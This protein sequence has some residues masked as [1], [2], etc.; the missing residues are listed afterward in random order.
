[1]HFVGPAD[2][3]N[4]FFWSADFAFLC[5]PVSGKKFSTVAE[6]HPH[7]TIEMERCR[8]MCQESFRFQQGCQ[9]FLGATYQNG[10]KCTKLTQIIPNGHKI[11][12]M[13][14]K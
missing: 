10:E 4:F 14:L 5:S 3:F 11:Y 6:C 13:A 9:I 7:F 12:Q 2:L 8:Q 1:L